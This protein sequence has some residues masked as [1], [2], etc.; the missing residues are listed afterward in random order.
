MRQ[1]EKK[2]SEFSSKNHALG[3]NAC[4]NTLASSEKS[5]QAQ[6]PSPLFTKD[7]IGDY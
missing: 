2:E 6:A 1:D 4:D 3:S 7:N 5:G